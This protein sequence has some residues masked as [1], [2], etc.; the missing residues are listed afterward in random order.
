MTG[1]VQYDRT[2]TVPITIRGQDRADDITVAAIIDTGFDGFLSLPAAM[3]AL[4]RLDY[5]GQM[6]TT[7][8]GGFAATFDLH[9]AI[10]LF[11]DEERGIVLTAAENPPLI[12]MSLLYGSKL[13][14]DVVDGGA[15][16]IEPLPFDP[17][18]EGT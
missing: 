7:V 17:I 8:F 5:L 15:V 18:M 3:V 1:E 6:Q 14:V 13:T 4:L 10:V 2:A 11:A 16:S 9:P 12:G